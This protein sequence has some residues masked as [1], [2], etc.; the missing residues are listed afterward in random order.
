MSILL[1]IIGGLVTLVFMVFL[2]GLICPSRKADN[3]ENRILDIVRQPQQGP[4][5]SK[6][7]AAAA[8]VGK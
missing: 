4:E 6:Q 2:R 1:W 3:G 5:T 8:A 7:T